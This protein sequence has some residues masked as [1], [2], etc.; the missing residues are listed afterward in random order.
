M[1]SVRTRLAVA[2]LLVLLTVQTARAL[3]A[4]TAA[5]NPTIVVGVIATL[6][7]PGAMAGQDSLDG[8]TTAL[9]QMGGRFANQ[10]V[11]VVPVDDRGSPDVAM[12]VT[13]RLLEREKVDFILTAVSQ[14]SMA[15]IVKPLNESRT[16]ILNLDA[17]PDG[18]FGARCSASLFGLGTPPD[19]VSEAA[20]MHFA[21]EKYR[22][23]VVIG[24]DTRQ[25]DMAVAALRR[26]WGGEDVTVLK[27]RHGAATFAPEIRRIRELA[28]DAVYTLLS[29]G[30]GLAL[31]RDYAAAG[32]K[33][34]IPLLGVWSNFERPHLT[35]MDDQGLDLLNVAPWSPDL[36]SPLNKRMISD[37]ELEYGRPA[38]SWV[39]QGYDSA[40]LLEAAMKVTAGR[41]S[42]REAVRNALRRAEFASVRGGFRFETNHAPVINLYLRR[43]ARDAKGRLTEETRGV[44]AREWRGRDAAHC[45]MHWGDEAATAKPGAATAPKPVQ[46][47]PRK[48]PPKTPPQ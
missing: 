37:F 6:S 4:S 32:L 23:L 1:T 16:F 24:H 22:R 44:L 30:M 21:N 11:R 45:P 2:L 18:L 15:A 7:G 5:G 28:P 47:P 31:V 19:A 25:T 42:D 26:T 46:A 40:L 39:A 3:P 34:D 14:A 13:R 35:A 38:T 17:Y 12:Q 9:R 36:D 27:A 41:T 43:V 33:A 8:F 29:G 10:E 20:G 48:P